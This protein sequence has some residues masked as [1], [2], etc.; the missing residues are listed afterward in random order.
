MNRV[1]AALLLTVLAGGPSADNRLPDIQGPISRIGGGVIVVGDRPFIMRPTT[2]IET[3][4]GQKLPSSDL[5][6]GDRA[7]AYRSPDSVPGRVPMLQ[8][9]VVIPIEAEPASR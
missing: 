3:R 9:L 5:R 2:V 7:M 4:L 1:A 6:P 8:R